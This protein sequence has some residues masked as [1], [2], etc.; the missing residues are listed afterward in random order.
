MADK[1]PIVKVDH[2]MKGNSPAGLKLRKALGITD[3]QKLGKMPDG[4]IELDWDQD[5]IEDFMKRY[6]SMDRHNNR[7]Q[8]RKR[9]NYAIWRYIVQLFA[10]HMSYK[11]IADKV[12]Q[13]FEAYNLPD[14]QCTYR[15]VK[16]IINHRGWRVAHRMRELISSERAESIIGARKE[17]CTKAQEMELDMLEHLQSEAKACL[18]SL[19]GLDPAEKEYK[20]VVSSLKTL[21]AEIERISG[22]GSVRKIQEF[23]VKE[24]IKAENQSSHKEIDPRKMI[25]TIHTE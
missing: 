5:E 14:T 21:N 11:G 9:W 24:Q 2:V 20:S 6:L 25:P 13:N 23:Q 16:S 19:R 1:I 22:T 10:E 12:S 7:F 15:T 17:A 3:E 8:N 18:H 4:S